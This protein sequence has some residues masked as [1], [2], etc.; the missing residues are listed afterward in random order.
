MEKVQ[1]FIWQIQLAKV[2]EMGVNMMCNIFEKFG[3]KS[4]CGTGFYIYNTGELVDFNKWKGL[5]K[6]YYNFLHVFLAVIRY[7]SW[8]LIPIEFFKYVIIK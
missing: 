4:A 7:I 3:P 8:K 5:V 2:V 6:Y 1:I